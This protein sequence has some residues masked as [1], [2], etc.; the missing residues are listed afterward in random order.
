MGSGSTSCIKIEEK[1]ITNWSE[2]VESVLF[3]I[4][5]RESTCMQHTQSQFMIDF[6]VDS[7]KYRWGLGRR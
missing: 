6:C 7:T 3:N 4:C 2:F 5:I 1:Y